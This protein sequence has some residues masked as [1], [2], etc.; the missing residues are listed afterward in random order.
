MLCR[1][2]TATSAQ[3]YKK[4][5]AQVMEYF[6]GANDEI[7]KSIPGVYHRKLDDKMLFRNTGKVSPVFCITYPRVILIV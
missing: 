2:S 4:W 3:M 6:N 5:T 1:H 7:Y